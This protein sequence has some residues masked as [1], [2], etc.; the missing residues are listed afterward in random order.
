MAAARVITL[1]ECQKHTTEDNCWLV[2]HGKVYDV[3]EFLDE[4][5]G[6]FD[7]VLSSTG[8]DATE[9]FEEIG[10]SNAAKEMLE[11]YYIG[12][13]E[14]G[15]AATSKVTKVALQRTKQQSS[16]GASLLKALLPIL[17]IVAAVLFTLYGK[18]Q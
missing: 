14:G 7:I 16:A 4:H 5:P 18:Q 2:I 1:D 3:S 6:G 9:D 13:Y 15:A 17:V 11:K 12:E 10:H 8:R